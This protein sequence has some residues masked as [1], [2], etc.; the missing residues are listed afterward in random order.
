MDETI[1]NIIGKLNNKYF[2]PSIQR[3]FVWCNNLKDNKIEK[4]FDSLMRGFPIGQIIL[5][6]PSQTISVYK[7]L[8]KYNDGNKDD[9]TN[10]IYDDKAGV[11]YL[12]LDGQ[13]RLTAFH[14]GIS[15][16][17]IN[18]KGND[19]YMYINL[20]YKADNDDSEKVNDL[21]YGFEFLT[22]KQAESFSEKELWF[23]VDKIM[24]KYNGVNDFKEKT[25][26]SLIANKDKNTVGIIRSNKKHIKDIM[27]R[28][29]YNIRE[30][31]LYAEVVSKDAGDDLLNIF[32]RLNDGGVKL[33]KSDFLLS[34]MENENKNFGNEG[35]GAREAIT[36]FC[37]ELKKDRQKNSIELS[38]DNVLK[39]CL[40]LTDS[41]GIQYKVSNF[42]D[43][44]VE[45]ISG[46]WEN[47]KLSL[48][49]TLALMD[50]YNIDKNNLIYRNALLPIAYYLMKNKKL[51]D[52]YIKT[53]NAQYLTEHKKLINW[54]AIVSFKKV[55][56]ASSDTAL[57]NIRDEMSEDNNFELPQFSQNTISTENIKNW[58]D[59]A[60]YKGKNTQLLLSLISNSA[61]WQT[62]QD[63]IY[64]QQMFKE[65][66]YLNKEF[67]NSL[68]N[69]QLLGSSQNKVKSCGSPE[70]WLK[71]QKY[72]YATANCIPDM[73]LMPDDSIKNIE[74]RKKSVANIFNEFIQERKKLIIARLK[75][76]LGVKD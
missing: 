8:E 13:Q 61:E 5:W 56:G 75:E 44:T 47:I 40:F 12:V 25:Y 41:L 48:Q 58:V 73:R 62:E 36:F 74:E 22:T 32:V 68:L 20:F 71:E 14:I 64:P 37:K 70:E 31:E 2:L 4:L 46:N 63:H 52:K 35:K 16:K 29:W 17:I 59:G 76:Q 30:R 10:I 66:H 26:N 45:K 33:E 34:S 50:K 7:F 57:N 15:G 19:E 72:G 23:K 67:M 55:F 27:V 38:K 24:G 43:K 60:V 9:N 3:E 11:K 1:K 49:A 42:N 54:L 69:L 39:A 18:K 53:D 28:L 65:N 51:G 6:K 21:S